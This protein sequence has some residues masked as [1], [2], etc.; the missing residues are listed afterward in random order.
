MQSST[1]ASPLADLVA[2]T[3]PE[4]GVDRSVHVPVVMSYSS[5]RV[6]VSRVLT[7]EWPA[8]R[9]SWDRHTIP[10]LRLKNRV[11]RQRNREHSK[12]RTGPRRR[13]LAPQPSTATLLHEGQHT[14]TPRHA[15]GVKHTTKLGFAS[16]HV[17]LAS[18][19]VHNH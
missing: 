2:G 12:R 14:E 8:A 4:L 5:R 1:S 3:G 6:R 9:R 15:G 19:L 11:Q 7:G 13:R 10:R 17:H 18:G 16:E